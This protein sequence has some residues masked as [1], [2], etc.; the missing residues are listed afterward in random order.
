[1]VKRKIF[2]GGMGE[3]S[4][5]R[6]N[7]RP[8]SGSDV[9]VAKESKIDAGDNLTS[10][11]RGVTPIERDSDMV[12]GDDED[13]DC[14]SVTEDRSSADEFADSKVRGPMLSSRDVKSAT[15][16]RSALFS[17]GRSGRSETAPISPQLSG[18]GSSSGVRLL[19]RDDMIVG[20][21]AKSGSKTMQP[22]SSFGKS[23]DQK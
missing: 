11:D 8:P 23:S 18:E 9:T 17:E 13:S 2:P 1:M 4:E 6:S 5:S 20:I 19:A 12:L 10:E 22:Q 21:A 3:T 7:S 15:T 16:S 14:G